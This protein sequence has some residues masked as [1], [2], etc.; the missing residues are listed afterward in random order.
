[1]TLIKICGI[2]REED[3]LFAAANGADFLGFIFVPESPRCVAPERA[4]EI[5]ESVRAAGNP[6]R[7]V[8]V[9]RNAGVDEV[10]HIAAQSTVDMIQL[11]GLEDDVFIRNVDRP[12]I[13]TIH[14]GESMPDVSSHPAAR[15]LLFDTLHDRLAGGTG[16]RFDWSLLTGVERSRPFFLSGGLTPGN[17]VAAVS[18]VR[19]AAIDVA[20]G[21]ESAPG[22]KDHRKLASLLES[23]RRA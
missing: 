1:M 9:F 5:A 16:Q 11:H 22:I 3:A 8:G 21:V 14:V 4:R 19:P 20:S 23:V 15:W 12:A 7:T 6:V 10:R 18:L 2:T 17:V 13:K